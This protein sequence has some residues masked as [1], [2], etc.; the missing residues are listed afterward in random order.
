MIQQ[1]AYY[2]LMQPV[3]STGGQPR[4]PPRPT[5]RIILRLVRGKTKTRSPYVDN[6][7]CG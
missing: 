6:P 3:S 1:K 7:R 2:R 5:S 4:E